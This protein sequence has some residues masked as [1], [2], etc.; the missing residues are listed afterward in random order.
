MTL[1]YINALF[2]AFTHSPTVQNHTTEA[3]LRAVNKGK[4]RKAFLEA[5]L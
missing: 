1:I 4:R 5:S 2:Q 3:E